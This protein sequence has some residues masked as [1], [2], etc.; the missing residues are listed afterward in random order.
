SSELRSLNREQR[1]RIVELRHEYEDL[2][3]AALAD[4]VRQ[5]KFDLLDV[6]VVSSGILALAT[7]V[8]NWYSPRGRLSL[9][10][11]AQIYIGLVLGG[12]SRSR[13]PGMKQPSRPRMMFAFRGRARP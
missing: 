10:D 1:N 2:F 6:Q 4:G 9:D 8:S 12:I 13:A 5:G 11:I 7:S 3:R